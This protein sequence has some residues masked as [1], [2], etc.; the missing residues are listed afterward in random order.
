MSGRAASWIAAILLTHCG[1][2]VHEPVAVGTLERDRIELIAEAQERVLDLA[3]REGDVVK[4]GDLLVKLDDSQMQARLAR[5]ASAQQGADARLRELVRGPRREHIA[6][7]EARLAAAES[8]VVVSRQ[9]LHRAQIQAHQ[10]LSRPE[11]G[12]EIG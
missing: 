2:S 5:A 7:A 6:E 3:V 8:T 10:P 9:D 11:M 4:K 1:E 12:L